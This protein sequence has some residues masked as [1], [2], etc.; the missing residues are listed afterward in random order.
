MRSRFK[1]NKWPFNDSFERA[2]RTED[3]DR[4]VSEFRTIKYCQH[5]HITTFV[6][7]LNEGTYN[8]FVMRKSH[9]PRI[10]ITQLFLHQGFCRTS[11]ALKSTLVSNLLERLKERTLKSVRTLD[12][13]S[14]VGAL[15]NRLFNS[16]EARIA[17][18]SLPVCA[19]ASKSAY[20]RWH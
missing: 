20:W 14:A 1:I 16:L 9:T 3:N 2:D 19:R 18:G 6:F 7:T 5:T 13:S 11:L 15:H 4:T 17:S 10:C 8:E 12:R